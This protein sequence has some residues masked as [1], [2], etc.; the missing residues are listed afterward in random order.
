MRVTEV[1]AYTTSRSPP[2][3]GAPAQIV[4]ACEALAT[5]EPGVPP[6]CSRAARP[7]ADRHATETGPGTGITDGSTSS[8]RPV[9]AVQPSAVAALTASVKNT[10]VS[11]S[12]RGPGR[13]S[14]AGRAL[15]LGRR[16]RAVAGRRRAAD[17]A[18][19]GLAD[20]A[21]IPRQHVPVRVLPGGLPRLRRRQRG[22]R[23]GHLR[24]ILPD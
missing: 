6:Q 15:Q 16:A 11:R 8:A 1:R 5:A 9:S 7:S 24:G 21:E 14:S 3:A 20:G 23:R 12:G 19:P 4:P 22:D 18:Q 10:G 17:E 2:D 13:G